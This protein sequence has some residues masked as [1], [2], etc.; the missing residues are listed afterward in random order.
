V[1]R[2]V[3]AALVILASAAGASSALAMEL[4]GAGD[5]KHAQERP[6]AADMQRAEAPARVSQESV[7]QSVYKV[8]M[9]EHGPEVGAK[10]FAQLGY[11]EREAG[12]MSEVAI[13]IVR[14]A[15]SYDNFKAMIAGKSKATPLDPREMA[16]IRTVS[17]RAGIHTAWD[18]HT[19]EGS[20]IAAKPDPRLHPKPA[21]VWDGRTWEGSAVR[22]R[23]VD[24][25]KK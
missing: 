11:N 5:P 6:Q 3:F 2:Q 8:A 7:L 19:W 10:A 24:E 15:G 12:Q 4:Q 18:G 13:G 14:K 20:S 17:T 22:V 1:D 9:S 21:S 16:M 23:P 25:R